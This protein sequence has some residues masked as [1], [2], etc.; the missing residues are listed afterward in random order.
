MNRV[1][2]KVCGKENQELFK[3]IQ[4]KPGED[5]K[6]CYVELIKSQR[7]TNEEM[8]NILLVSKGMSS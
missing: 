6:K 5:M 1:V 2:T 8:N 4:E 3:C 7:C